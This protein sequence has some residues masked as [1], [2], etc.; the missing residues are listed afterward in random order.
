MLS[1]NYIRVQ[2]VMA[3]KLEISSNMTTQN[4]DNIDDK[5]FFSKK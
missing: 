1:P 2:S 4:T 3:A 5:H